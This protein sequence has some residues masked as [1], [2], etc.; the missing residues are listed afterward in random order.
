[1][2]QDYSAN[3][4][5][6]FLILCNTILLNVLHN[7]SLKVLLPWQNTGF[8]TSPI[9]KTFLATFGIPFW[10]LLMMPPIDDPISYFI[11]DSSSLWP[12]LT[13]FKL[14]ITNMLKSSEWGWKRVNCHGN[15][16]FIAIGVFPVEV[17]AYQVSMVCIA[18][19]PR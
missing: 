14:K 6:K 12:C 9:F 3:V 5:Q 11:Y 16:I 19:W 18:N 17:L 10:Y 15:R 7:T 13:V 8:K 4:Y 1:M 2:K